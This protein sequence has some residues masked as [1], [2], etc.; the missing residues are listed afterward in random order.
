MPKEPQLEAFAKVLG[1]ME[2]A[3]FSGS[4][5]GSDSEFYAVPHPGFFI[6]PNLTERANSKDMLIISNLVNRCFEPE[7]RYREK[8]TTVTQ[9]YSDI[10]SQAALPEQELSEEEEDKLIK[11]EQKLEEMF[12]A[13][14]RYKTRYLEAYGYFLA[15][16]ESDPPNSSEVRRLK[17]KLDSARDEWKLTGRKEAYEKASAQVS[18]LRSSS[19]KTH[20]DNLQK[21]FSDHT[22]TSGV[23]DYQATYLSPPIAEWQSQFTSWTRFEKTFKY[24]NLEVLSKHTSW[25]GKTGG[26]WGL[27]KAKIKV[28]GS[29]VEEHEE[30][31]NIDIELKFDFLRVRIIRPWM[32]SDLFSYNFWTYQKEFGYRQVSEGAILNAP[33]GPR[34]LMPVIPT[35]LVIVKDVSI[36]ANFGEK[37]RDF[38]KKILSGSAG[39]GW[40]PIGVKGSYQTTT[41]SEDVEGSFDGTTLKVHNPQVIGIIGTLLPACPNPQRELPWGDDAAF[42]P[43]G[44]DKNTELAGEADEPYLKAARE[45]WELVRDLGDGESSQ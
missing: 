44:K 17:D 32:V 15:A 45:Q 26:G 5:G 23:G 10:L 16:Q 40:G 30:S 6:S 11:L 3:I 38:I 34:G 14:S 12:P 27:W 22:Q 2:N 4:T 35:D 21:R 41:S 36:T 18:Y 37:E 28:G 7:M 20:F 13:Y 1:M 9:V 39:G 43:A 8:V 29:T 33:V 19:P 24:S 42:P 25:S 31:E